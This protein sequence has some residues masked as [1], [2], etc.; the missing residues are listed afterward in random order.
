[1]EYKFSLLTDVGRKRAKNE[2]SIGEAKTI[3]GHVFVVCD[4]MGGH[5]GG[6]IASSLG[7]KSILDFFERELYQNIYVAINNA[8]QF[9]NEQ[10]YYKSVEDPSLQGMGTTLVL[11]IIRDT[12]VY[13]AHVGDSRIYVM[14]GGKL[15]QLTIDHSLV[16]KL[17]EKGIIEASE[18]ESHPRKNEILRAMGTTQTVE[19]EI[20]EE[21][22]HPSKGDI[23]LLCSDGLSGMISY[24]VISEILSNSNALNEKTAKLISMANDAGGTDNISVELIEISGSVGLSSAKAAAVNEKESGNESNVYTKKKPGRKSKK[25]WY[26]LG[27]IAVLVIVYAI[28]YVF[29][30]RNKKTLDKNDSLKIS[31]GKVSSKTGLVKDTFYIVQRGDSWSK[32]YEK[33]GVCSDLIKSNPKNKFYYTENGPIEKSKLTI[34]L[35]YSSKPDYNP[36]YKNYPSKDCEN[37][38]KG[39][40]AENQ[41]II[42]S[43][44]ASDQKSGQSKAKNGGQ[45]KKDGPTGASGGTG[46]ATKVGAGGATGASGGTG[47]AKNVGTGGATG[48]PGG[49]VGPTGGSGP[50]NK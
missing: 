33:Y 26:M 37:R 41:I 38:I 21:P 7:V 22:Y 44:V 49:V 6:Q 25:L 39:L 47:G 9:A 27:F 4:G 20:M 23:F 2:D 42:Q 35:K 13:L 17:V 11:L 34:P 12:D 50:T 18:A 40:K 3:N 16:Q 10:I 31:N 32:I 46:G 19:P 5:V 30:N 15:S 48:V 14:S 29:P 24:K 1:M 36:D 45:E 28:V 8:I 43:G